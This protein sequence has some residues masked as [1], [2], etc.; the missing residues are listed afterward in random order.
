MNQRWPIYEVA[1]DEVVRALGV[2]NINY[3]RFER[4]HVWMLAAT[5]NLTEEQAA[6]FTSRTNPNERAT[7]IDTFF[8][9]RQ[10][11]EPV[12]AAI[13][14]YIAAMRVLTEN[15]NALIHGNIVTGWGNEPAIFS[16][17]RRG[18]M[19]MF[20]SSLATIRQVAD[21]A[22]SYFQFGLALANYIAVEIHG[23][24]RQAG[25][26]VVHDC[27]PCPPMPQP[28]RPIST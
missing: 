22:E 13:K 27:P 4:T 28:V 23:A 14:H 5:A 8:K 18:E 25:M 16:L 20:K 6:I 3:V 1:D 9:R 26:V 24:A 17:S 10:W 12:N 15:R 11:P 2:M 19:V 7:F 21:E